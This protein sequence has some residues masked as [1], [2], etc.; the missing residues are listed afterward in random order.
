MTVKGWSL[1]H[2]PPPLKSKETHD[3]FVEV[4]EGLDEMVEHDFGV[5]FEQTL[6]D[7]KRRQM[8]NLF[9]RIAQGLDDA[10]K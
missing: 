4:E 8:T 1:N 5:T 6:L 7:V 10:K 9:F 2:C 3:V